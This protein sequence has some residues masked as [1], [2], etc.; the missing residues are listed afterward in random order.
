MY[1]YKKPKMKRGWLAL[2]SIIVVVV[3]AVLIYNLPPV[4]QRLGWR[5]EYAGI[6]LKS[7]FNPV[8]PMPTPLPYTPPPTTP[9][10]AAA[11]PTPGPMLSATPSPTPTEIPLPV[12]MILPPPAYEREDLNNCG[13]AALAM[14]LRFYGWEGDQYTISDVIKPFD[15]DRNVNVE[16]LI[17]YANNYTGWLR[18]EF[19]VGGNT[20]LLRKLIASGI[21]VM[22][23]GSYIVDKNYWANDDRWAGHYTL[24]T[25]YKDAEQTFITQ[26]VFSGPDRVMTYEELDREWQT[27]NRVYILLFPPEKENEIKAIL[28]SNW[29]PDQ[30][31]QNALDTARIETET[32]P[33]NP[34]TWFNLGSNLVYFEKY[35]EAALA[36][37]QARN[38]DGTASGEDAPIN[39]LPQR[40]LRYQFGPFLAYF[41]SGRT[42]D[43]MALTDYALLRTPNSEEALLWR[44]W[45]LYRLGDKIEAVASFQKALE[46]R[47]GYHDA[48]YALEFVQSN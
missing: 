22:I 44:G 1:S 29:D 33:E 43:L 8:Q 28:G 41:H 26:D 16:E 5:V 39:G 27:F 3:V 32:D 12:Q 40:M 37:D 30:N 13:P 45:G 6:Y 47:P 46:A 31:R 20:L 9:T 2:L 11:S 14:Y 25:G 38:S 7:M 34:F 24:V 4:N 15:R 36:Y 19:R 23:E 48:Q 18:T 21:P 35:T 10:A 17:Y 42:D